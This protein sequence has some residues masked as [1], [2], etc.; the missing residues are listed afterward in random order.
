[1]FKTEREA[2]RVEQKSHRKHQKELQNYVEKFLDDASG[3]TPTQIRSLAESYNKMWEDYA[4]RNT[5]DDKSIIVFGDAFESSLLNGHKHVKNM[6]VDLKNPNQ[7]ERL[8]Q[9]KRVFEITRKPTIL[10]RLFPFLRP[11]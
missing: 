8:K 1:M 3:K 5:K 2:R 4:K 7:A 11:K 6:P 10:E 9:F